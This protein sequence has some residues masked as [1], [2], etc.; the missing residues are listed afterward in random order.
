[1]D[2]F[3]LTLGMFSIYCFSTVTMVT[4]ACL[5]VVLYVHLVVLLDQSVHLVVLLDQSVHLVVLLDQSVHYYVV[6]LK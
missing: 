3:K 2:N 6:C 5:S 1:M 4:G